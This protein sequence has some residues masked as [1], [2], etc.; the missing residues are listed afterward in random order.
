MSDDT[1]QSAS[2]A[3]AHAGHA[4][5]VNADTNRQR[6]A[7]AL[8]L[9]V[10]FM[11]AEVV[12]GILARSLAL[13]S[14]AAHMVSDAGAI[15]LSL[16]ALSLAARP[17]GG[18]LTFGLKRAEILS[19]QANGATLLVL[20]GLIVYEAIH[21]LFEPPE[22]QGWAVLSVA[23]AGVVVNLVATWF[24]AKANR[25]NMAVEGSF[26]HIVTD[27]YAFIG[28]AVAGIVIVTTGFLRADPIAS[29]LVAALM[30]RAAYGLLRDSGRILLEMTPEGLSAN[31]IGRALAS[32]PN[33][34]EVHDLHVWEIATG[35]PS[36][37][38]HVLVRPGDDCHGVRRELERTLDERFGIDHTTLQVDHAG[39]AVVP[40]AG[41]L[42]SESSHS[43]SDR[44]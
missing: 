11:A 1:G 12:V 9:I 3:G 33:V 22:V 35:F 21:R 5:V 10:V 14:D 36:L 24:L 7:L 42:V 39:E 19:A 41:R 30:L 27:L 25:E 18:N 23:L 17:A 32:H 44:P 31:E 6:L 40:L 16:V 2:R 13:L 4:H 28:T 38:A 37:S 29:L 15:G 8:A 26:Q 34:A 43:E 20:A